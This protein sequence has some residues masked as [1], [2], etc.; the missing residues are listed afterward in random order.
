MAAAVADYR[1]IDV[2]SQKLKKTGDGMLL[3]LEPNP[4]ILADLGRIKGDRLLVGFAA[5]G[6]A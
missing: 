6:V 5:V 4:D 2:V 1:V 3:Q